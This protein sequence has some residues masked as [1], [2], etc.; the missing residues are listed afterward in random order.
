MKNYYLK[1]SHPAY[2][3]FVEEI[4]KCH[5]DQVSLLKAQNTISR[6]MTDTILKAESIF[7]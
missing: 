2:L 7:G 4:F 3:S 6:K 1:N 5:F